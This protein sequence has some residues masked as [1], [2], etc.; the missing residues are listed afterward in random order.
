MS[1]KDYLLTEQNISSEDII[2][3]EGS[4]L[5]K[6]QDAEKLITKLISVTQ[7]PYNKLIANIIVD[8]IE[9]VNIPNGLLVSV[10]I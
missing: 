6:N 2:E 5:I 10:V 1:I 3:K 7:H 4:I 9:Y 8:G